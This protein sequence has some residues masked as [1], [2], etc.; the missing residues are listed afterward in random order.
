MSFDEKPKLAPAP[1]P[2]SQ[3]VS[4]ETFA[5]E[6]NSTIAKLRELLKDVPP[7]I[8]CAAMVVMCHGT[9]ADGHPMRSAFATI[10]R[11][12]FG[13]LKLEKPHAGMKQ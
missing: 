1:A 2:V 4:A 3:T 10:I 13:F 9:V 11:K 6:V 8:G 7:P 5:I 12:N